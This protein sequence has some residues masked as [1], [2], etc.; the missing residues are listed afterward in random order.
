MT[1]STDKNKVDLFAAFFEKEI[2]LD[3]SDSLPFHQ[4]VTEHLT[5]LFNAII[6]IGYIPTEWKK[7]NNILILKQKKDKNQPSSYRPI[8][9][10]SWIG[11][12][13]E[14]IIK[15]R[16]TTVL[17]KRNIVPAHQSGLRTKKS[18]MYN[19]TR[20]KRYAKDQLGKQRHSA[21]IFF[22]IKAAFDSV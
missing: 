2:F 5:H 1:A 15:Q 3:K 6:S 13:L 19:I 9:L 10:L 12:I 18:T 16:L 14:K 17:D 20:L 21:T 4:Q 7:A 11:K 22:D 8:S